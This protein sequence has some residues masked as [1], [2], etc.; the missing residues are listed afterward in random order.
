MQPPPTVLS[1][2]LIADEQGVSGLIFLDLDAV[3][4]L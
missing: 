2:A 3:R 4:I 1:L